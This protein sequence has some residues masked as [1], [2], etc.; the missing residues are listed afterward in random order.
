MGRSLRAIAGG[1]RRTLAAM[2]GRPARARRRKAESNLVANSGLFDGEW[3]LR[4]YPDVAEAGTD[5]LRHF[6]TCGW[7]EGRDPGPEFATSAYLRANSDVARSGINPLLHYIEF[8]HAEGRGTFGHRVVVRSRATQSFDFADPAPC[9]SFLRL[10]ERALPWVRAYRLDHERSDTLE[11]GNVPIGYCS[12]GPVQREVESAL[13]LF[14]RLS[15]SEQRASQGAPGKLTKTEFELVDG[16]YLNS[17]QLRTRWTGNGRQFVVRALQHDPL[18][19][20]TIALAGEGLVASPLDVVDFQLRDAFYPLLFIFCDLDGAV[21]GCRLLAFPSLCRGGAHYPELVGAA[22]IET[23]AGID[24]MSYNEVLAGRLLALLDGEA[25]PAVGHIT[26]ELVGTKGAPRLL[27]PRMRGWLERI[28][29]VAV[30]A[31]SPDTTRIHSFEGASSLEARDLRRKGTVRLCLSHDMIPTIA[32]LTEPRSAKV[33]KGGEAIVPLLAAGHEPAMPVSLVAFPRDLTALL[34]DL[35]GQGGAPWPRLVAEKSSIPLDFPPAAI[36]AH[37]DSGPSDA[38][39]LV[40][41]ADPALPSATRRREAITW[42][43]EASG[44][45]EGDLFLALHSLGTQAGADHDA[46]A[47]V[48]QVD[49]ATLS[50]AHERFDGRAAAFRD[51]K[52][53]AYGIGTPLAAFVGPGTMLHDP[54]AALELSRL[55]DHESVETASCV[56][57]RGEK[58]GRSWH[59]A[60]LDLGEMAGKTVGANDDHGHALIGQLWRSIYPVA[61][62]ARDLWL[63]RAAN[64]RAWIGERTGK[65]TGGYHLCSFMVTASNVGSERPAGRSIAV[66]RAPWDHSLNVRA[67]VG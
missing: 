32:A 12:K 4:N 54:R 23:Q 65:T 60:G 22:E 50:M 16:W 18:R 63:A 29:R 24:L 26:Y 44:W 30:E 56:L 52:A 11:I 45:H 5:P 66:P 15:A 7:Q 8:G 19:G 3:Y 59:A 58:P 2:N 14:A 61:S 21:L 20:G 33:A 28:L 9:S 35:A 51:F 17:S 46:L 1:V 57:I 39:L 55:L 64:V 31:S 36:R 41:L 40:P 47:I 25:E 10:E 37:G 34:G 48:G 38:E 49:G 43:V 27:Q 53:A 13:G 6:M 62:P 67:D 42:V